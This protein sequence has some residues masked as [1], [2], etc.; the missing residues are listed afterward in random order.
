M[1]QLII[2]YVLIV[3]LVIGLGYLIYLFKDKGVSIN[4]DYFGI[5]YSILNMLGANEGTPD[6]IKKV[7]RA[8]RDAVSYVETNYK[9]ADNSLKE[10]KALE[11]AK[12]TLKVLNFQNEL[13]DDSIIYL[14]RLACAFLPATNKVKNIIQ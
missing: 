10:K 5:A 2:Q 8:V 13:S 1:F 9:D 3:M 6:N 12:D 11:L 4:E 7:L 14:I